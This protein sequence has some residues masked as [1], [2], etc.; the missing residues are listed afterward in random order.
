MKNLKTYL[1]AL[2]VAAGLQ[3][4]SAQSK[5]GYTNLFNGKNLNGWKIGRQSRV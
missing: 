1:L 5:A 4:A 2:T 3:T